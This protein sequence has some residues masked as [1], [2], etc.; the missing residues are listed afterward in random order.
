MIV[1]IEG[2]EVDTN[3]PKSARYIQCTSVITSIHQLIKRVKPQSCARADIPKYT[4][5]IM[6][7]MHNEANTKHYP[8]LPPANKKNKKKV[9]RLDG[10]PDGVRD[11]DHVRGVVVKQVQEYDGLEEQ[12]HQH[13]AHGNAFQRPANTHHNAQPGGKQLRAGARGGGRGGGREHKL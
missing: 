13:R 5:R 2:Q 8:S 11:H 7:A 4:T 12:V 9:T 1:T 10:Q 3:R 6:N